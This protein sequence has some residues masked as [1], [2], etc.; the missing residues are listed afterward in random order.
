MPLSKP[1]ITF[2]IPAYNSEPFLHV[3]LDSLMRFDSRIEVLVIDDGSTDKTFEIAKGYAAR[4]PIFRDIHQENKGHG[5]AVNTAIKEAK[6]RFFKVLDSDDWVDVN[7]LNALLVDIERCEAFPDV[8]IMDYTYWEGYERENTTITYERCLPERRTTSMDSVRR[9]LIKQNFT[10]HSAMFRTELLRVS[11]VNLPEHCSYD[12]NYLVYAC[13]CAGKTIRYLHRSLYQYMIGREGQSMSSE[14]LYRK[15]GDIILTSELV[16][17]YR[18]IAPLKKKN[19]GLYRLLMH[20]LYLIVCMVPT[21]CQINGSPEATE[22]M[23][24]FFDRCKQSKPEQY[25]L[26]RRHLILRLMT[27]KGKLGRFNTRVV[28]GVARKVVKFN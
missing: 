24:A 25:K 11:E 14:N 8:Y 9:M 16:Y 21:V 6:G 2:C 28:V 20:H 26:V 18:D 15:W 3:A 5:G 23:R 22:A 10:V 4:F 13:L 17:Q 19:P 12:D 7:A 1:Y 27:M